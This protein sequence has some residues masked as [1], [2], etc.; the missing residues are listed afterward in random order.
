MVF[1][2]GEKEPARL[3]VG[4][5]ALRQSRLGQQEV[6]IAADGLRPRF[7]SGQSLAR[8]RQSV[9]ALEN[10]HQPQGGRPPALSILQYARQGRLCTPRLAHRDQQLS[11]A[12]DDLGRQPGEARP[13]FEDRHGLFGAHDVEATLRKCKAQSGIRRGQADRSAEHG[14]GGFVVT[15]I[16]VQHADVVEQVRCDAAELEG[17]IVSLEGGVVATGRAQR[18]AEIAPV[19]GAARLEQGECIEYAH[20]VLVTPLGM[21]HHPENVQRAAMLAIGAECAQALGFGLCNLVVL[22]IASGE[23]GEL[24]GIVGG[25]HASGSALHGWRAWR[26]RTSCKSR[27]PRSGSAPCRRL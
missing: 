2:N 17:A 6:G 21:E 10:P 12:R 22:Q 18:R 19:L 15:P 1:Q 24:S 27:V 20:R 5:V 11:D 16:H 9:G 4:T 25:T 14:A 23:L 8:F 13:V 3:L 26:A 7:D